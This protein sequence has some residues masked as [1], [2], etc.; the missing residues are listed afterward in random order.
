[1][2]LAKQTDVIIVGAG[3]AGITAAIQLKR[4]GI[5]YLLIEENRVGGLL[6]NANLVENYPGF[7]TGVSG[8]KLVGLFEKQ[9]KH[10][11]VEVIFEKVVCAGRSNELFVVETQS[12]TYLANFLVIAS[13]T[14][15]MPFPI[16]VSDEMK[17]HVFSDVA[18]LLDVTRRHIVIVGSGDAAYDHALNLVRN[19]NCVTILN[20]GQDVKCLPLLVERARLQPAIKYR[21]EITI[22]RVELDRTGRLVIYCRTRPSVEQIQA[23]DL[24]FAIG[25]EAQQDYFSGNLREKESELTSACKLYFIGDV[26][27]GLMRQTA[28]A[29]GDGLRAAMQIDHMLKDKKP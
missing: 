6:W 1:M 25:R 17:G 14:K 18:H 12:G 26:R 22:S 3:P 13:G 16:F 19:E 7:P 29:T 21:D 11:A 24:I 27:N 8:P 10:N 9:M 2:A 28:I 4:F 20:R 15:A 5:P 23:D